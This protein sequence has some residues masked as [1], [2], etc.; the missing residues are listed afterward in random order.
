MSQHCP[1]TTDSMMIKVALL[2][3]EIQ[4]VEGIEFIRINHYGRADELRLDDIEVHPDGVVRRTFQPTAS[5][6]LTP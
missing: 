3:V 2:E 6:S 5:M 1:V 4:E